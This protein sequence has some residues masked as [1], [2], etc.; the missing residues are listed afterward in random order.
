MQWYRVYETSYLR[1]PGYASALF[2]VGYGCIRIFAEIWRLPDAHIGYLL[3]TEWV[4]L[5]MLYSLP[6]ILG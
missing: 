1:T 6:M 5:G 4:T 2:L 3:G